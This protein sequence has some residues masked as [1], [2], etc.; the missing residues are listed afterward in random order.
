MDEYWDL[1]DENRNKLGKT[2]LRAKPLEEGTYHIVVNVWIINSKNEI[3]LAQRHPDKWLGGMWECAASG[4]VLAGED[5]LQGAVREAKEEIGVV[6]SPSDAILLQT[7]VRKDRSD[8]RDTFLFNMDICIDDLVFHPQE[9][10]AAKW[11]TKQEY[12]YM[13]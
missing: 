6:L 8:I 3:L 12:E 10:I 1:Y 2:H 9:V 13:K 5:S 4:G 11:V 7:I